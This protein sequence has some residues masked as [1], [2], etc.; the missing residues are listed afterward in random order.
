MGPPGSWGAVGAGTVAPAI[1]R[2]GQPH[3]LRYLITNRLYCET[4]QSPG[5]RGNAVKTG[6]LICVLEAVK[7]QNSQPA[8]GS[9]MVK[10]INLEP[11]LPSPKTPP[12]W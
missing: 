11:A 3:P 4:F 6:D 5:P 7:L 10:A 8:P 12:S 2:E 9:G 1:L